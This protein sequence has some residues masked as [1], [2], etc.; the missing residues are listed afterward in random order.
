MIERI[1]H[2][3]FLNSIEQDSNTIFSNLFLPSKF[4]YGVSTVTTFA[5]N[6]SVVRYTSFLSYMVCDL[7]V[8][9]KKILPVL[10]LCKHTPYILLVS[11]WINFYLIFIPPRNC[12]ALRCVKKVPNFIFQMITQM[13]LQYLLNCPACFQW[14]C[15]AL[16]SK[17]DRK[18][19]QQSSCLG[20]LP[21]GGYKCQKE[22]DVMCADW[23]IYLCA[24]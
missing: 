3:I 15:V 11:L 18:T 1:L 13:P 7:G 9:I 6:F 20:H 14:V 19:A 22:A 8:M 5:C 21:L 16:K 24:G 10:Q 2:W 23:C 4:V 12:F 17:D